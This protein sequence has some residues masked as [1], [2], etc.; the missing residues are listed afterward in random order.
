[1][2][3]FPPSVERASVKPVF[4]LAESV[5]SFKFA[6]VANLFSNAQYS[7]FTMIPSNS[8]VLAKTRSPLDSRSL[9]GALA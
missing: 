6:T 3:V 9:S 2:N 7:L 1:M 4:W 5:P 8:P